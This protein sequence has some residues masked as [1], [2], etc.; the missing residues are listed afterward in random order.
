MRRNTPKDRFFLRLFYPIVLMLFASTV[1]FGFESK[2]GTESQVP[3]DPT[4]SV[5]GQNNADNLHGPPLGDPALML[6]FGVSLISFGIAARHRLHSRAK[7]DAAASE[8]EGN[9]TQGSVKSVR[10]RAEVY[11]T[12]SDR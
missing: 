12:S 6:V 4:E 7:I 2:S 10:R 3:A 8:A 5:A 1:I 9:I 11:S